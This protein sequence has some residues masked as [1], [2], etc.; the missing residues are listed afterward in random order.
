[1]LAYVARKK[2]DEYPDT[3]LV[4]ANHSLRSILQDLVG[5]SDRRE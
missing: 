5:V 1:M 3:D 2:L 4:R